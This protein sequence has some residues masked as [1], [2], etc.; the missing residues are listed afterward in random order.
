MQPV[1]TALVGIS[2]IGGYHLSLLHDA[3]DLELVA[4]ADKW[5]DRERV[6]AAA[7]NVEEWGVP[8]YGDIWEMLDAV[9]VEAVTIATPHPYHAPYTLGA[10]DRG[11]HVMVEKPLTILASD[12]VQVVKK[13]ADKDLFVAVDFQYAGFE[14]SL[15]LKDLI[16]NGDLGELVEIVGVME[17]KRTEDYYKRSDWAGKRYYDGLACFDGTLMNQAVHLLNSALHMGTTA[18][19]RAVPQRLQ[20]EMY[21]VHNIE[22][23]DVACIR[24]DLGEATLHFYAT[25]CAE[26]DVRTTLDIVGTKGRASWD[27]DKAV[28]KI[29]GKDEIVFDMPSDRNAMHHNLVNCIRGAEKTLYAPA[30]E[31]VKPTLTVNGAYYSTQMIPKVSWDDL[32]DIRSL[33]DQAADEKKLL[34][35]MG[36]SWG[37]KTE[38]V[39]LEDFTKFA[40]LVDDEEVKAETAAR[41]EEEASGNFEWSHLPK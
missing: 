9:D 3:P 5:L 38:V 27:S 35:E 19:E 15:A 21:R 37:R 12:G 39:E 30:S 10:L 16:C 1:R 4:V 6:Q 11:L 14:H 18:P 2:G 33:M 7:K 22:C 31:S 29:D 32:G 24:A 40:G 41:G 17:W 25:T 20:A 13:A 34:S 28:V 26:A 23:E 36:V 8:I